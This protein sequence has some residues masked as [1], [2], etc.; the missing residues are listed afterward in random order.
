V[1]SVSLARKDVP[2]GRTLRED[3]FVTVQWTLN[4]PEDESISDKSI[5]RHHR[6]KRLLQEAERQSSAPTDEDLAGALGV[7]RRTILRDMQVLK[8]EIPRPPTRK[9]K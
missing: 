2:L 1:I 9:R 4:S 3:E 6:L 5:R 8:Q 7:S